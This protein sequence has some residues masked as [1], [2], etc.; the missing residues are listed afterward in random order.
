M[1]SQDVED[2]KDS[3]L[4]DIGRSSFTA[5]AIEKQSSSSEG[6][7]TAIHSFY[8]QV[9]AN[10]PSALPSSYVT[11]ESTWKESVWNGEG[12]DV[13]SA[14]NAFLL[15]PIESGPVGSGYGVFANEPVGYARGTL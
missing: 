4:V 6:N 8:G 9:T 1:I 7:H 14:L 11:G 12:F 15:S 2:V 3:E 13:R 5:S 10:E